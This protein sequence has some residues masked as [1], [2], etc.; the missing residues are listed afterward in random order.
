MAP[1][2]FRTVGVVGLGTMG[3][4][5]AEVLARSG[6]SV[7]GVEVDAAGVTRARESIE[8]S[9]ARAVVGGK[10]TAVDREA[11][12]GADRVRE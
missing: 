8:A 3:A 1:R 6:V 4:G 5:I 9:T 7:V 12:I 2:E 11:L 10:L